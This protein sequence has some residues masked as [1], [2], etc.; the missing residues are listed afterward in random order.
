[1]STPWGCKF[2]AF[3]CHTHGSY[4]RVRKCLP[5]GVT[6]HLYW[7]VNP[8]GHTELW[9][10]VT[11]SGYK[12]VAFECH[13]HGS[14]VGVRKCLPHGIAIVIYIGLSTHGS[15]RIMKQCPPLWVKNSQIADVSGNCITGQLPNVNSQRCDSLASGSKTT[16]TGKQSSSKCVAGP[17]GT[18]NGHIKHLGKDF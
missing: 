8:M 11:P 13:T 12:F 7:T 6:S 3:D 5:H 14:Y 18:S 9:N 1:M 15:H 17:K 2:I 16:N 4:I 10:N